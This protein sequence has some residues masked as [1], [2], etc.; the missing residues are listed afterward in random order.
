MQGYNQGLYILNSAQA[1][2]SELFQLGYLFLRVRSVLQASDFLLDVFNIARDT[3]GASSN[4]SYF[5]HV[6]IV[7]YENILEIIPRLRD[8]RYFADL[9][10]HV[11]NIILDYTHRLREALRV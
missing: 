1:V 5:L 9:H 6:G 2:Y 3:L 8:L 4:L 10:T 11:N 7:I